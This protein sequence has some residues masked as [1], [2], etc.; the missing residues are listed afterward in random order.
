MPL[1][2]TRHGFLILREPEDSFINYSL[3]FK[4]SDADIMGLFNYMSYFCYDII[5]RDKKPKSLQYHLDHGNVKR[6]NGDLYFKD[7]GDD[8]TDA[9]IPHI[10]VK[11]YIAREKLFNSISPAIPAVLAPKD[12]IADGLNKE[13]P[14][15]DLYR[16]QWFEEIRKFNDKVY[17]SIESNMSKYSSVI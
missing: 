4:V 14:I 6:I 10:N 3:I 16:R 13:N 2:E 9:L 8:F 5:E 15:R 17:R 12:V 11:L 7:L 1:S